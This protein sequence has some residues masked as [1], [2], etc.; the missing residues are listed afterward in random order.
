MVST[1]GYAPVFAASVNEVLVIGRLARA[2][3]PPR[4]GR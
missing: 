1:Y 2:V 4:S 3:P